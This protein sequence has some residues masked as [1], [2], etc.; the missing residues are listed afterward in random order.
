MFDEP[1][2]ASRLIDWVRK[3][4]QQV[5]PGSQNRAWNDTT[6][7]VITGKALMQIHGD[8]M[9]G[10]WRNAGKVAGK[11]FGCVNIPGTKALA[12][13]VDAWNF[14]DGPA[15]D[16][17]T[18]GRRAR[19]RQDRHRSAGDGGL[20]RQEGL[21]PGSPRCADRRLDQCNLLVLDSLKKP[22]FSVQNPFNISDADWVR[23]VWN[24]MFKFWGDQSMTSDDVIAELKDQYDTIFY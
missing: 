4:S 7:L 17:A 18:Q 13:T 16:D 23:S 14:L 3:F 19:I 6:N 24:V 2:L 11:D 20:R 10:E 1:A 22:D 12:V 15:V 9:K 8:W 5:D 21:D